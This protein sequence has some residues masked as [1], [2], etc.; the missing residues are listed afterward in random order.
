M[1]KVNPG[2]CVDYIVQCMGMYR[3]APEIGA[4]VFK[5]SSQ[6]PRQAQVNSVVFPSVCGAILCCQGS[7][8]LTQW[9]L[10]HNY[11]ICMGGMTF[12]GRNI[13]RLYCTMCRYAI[14]CG[15]LFLKKTCAHN[16]AKFRKLERLRRT[17]GNEWA[18]APTLSTSVAQLLNAY[19]WYEI[20]WRE[21][22][23][24]LL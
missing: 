19:V 3:C 7:Q 8:T 6:V 14:E 16:W 5:R 11:W 23:S 17:T 10:Q 13:C 4:F 18:H 9:K 2:R 12:R 24:T 21:Y 22:M 20:H 15:T 1:R